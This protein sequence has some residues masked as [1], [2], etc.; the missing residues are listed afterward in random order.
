VKGEFA[1]QSLRIREISCYKIKTKDKETRVFETREVH[2]ARAVLS[3]PSSLRHHFHF[4][5]RLLCGLS[6]FLIHF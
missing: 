2:L 6:M 1:H 3:A 5:F 4:S